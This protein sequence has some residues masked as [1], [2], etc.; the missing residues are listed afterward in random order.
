MKN[1]PMGEG[2]ELEIRQAFDA[3]EFGDELTPELREREERQRLRIE[4]DAARRAA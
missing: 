3:E 2:A 1:A 4:E